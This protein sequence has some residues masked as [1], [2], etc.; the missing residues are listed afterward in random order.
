MHDQFLRFYETQLT[1]R[2]HHSLSTVAIRLAVS[3]GRLLLGLHACW[4]LRSSNY[5]LE[6]CL[7]AIFPATLADLRATSPKFA[8]LSA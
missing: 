3:A 7:A 8:V 2:K 4:Q 5:L 1:G 6:V